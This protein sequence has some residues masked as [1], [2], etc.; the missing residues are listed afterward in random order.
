[1]VYIFLQEFRVE[2][3]GWKFKRE[4]VDALEFW[5]RVW[6]PMSSSWPV[7]SAHTH[8]LIRNTSDTIPIDNNAADVSTSTEIL[9]CLLR[10]NSGHYYV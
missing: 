3:L 4:R 8:R 5:L 1:M 9:R 10:P 2:G 7:P 6:V